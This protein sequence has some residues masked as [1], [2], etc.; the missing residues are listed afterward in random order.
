MIAQFISDGQIDQ[1]GAIFNDG[2]NPER[3]KMQDFKNLTKISQQPE[4]R[5]PRPHQM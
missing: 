3:I 5:E 4:A 1:M 2:G